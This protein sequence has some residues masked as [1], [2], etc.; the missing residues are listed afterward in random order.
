MKIRSITLGVSLSP[1]DFT[2]NQ[3]ITGISIKISKAKLILDTIKSAL[4]SE[5]YE[6]QTVRIS[7]NPMEEWI[8]DSSTESMGNIDTYNRES[9]KDTHIQEIMCRIHLLINEIVSHSISF[10][11][12]GGCSTPNLM[13]LIPNFLFL[14][15]RLYCSIQFHKNN[16]DF[17]SPNT[18]LL[19]I[20]AEVL[21][22]VH[23]VLDVSGCFRFCCSFNCQGDNPYFPVSY[24]NCNNGDYS[25]SIAMECGDLLFLSFFGAKSLSEGSLNLKIVLEQ[26]LKPVNLIVQNICENQ[27]GI[28]YAGI[29]ASINPGMTLPDSIGAGIENLFNIETIDNSINKDNH[30]KFGDFGT[31]AVVSAI[32]SA[33]KSLVSNTNSMSNN[34]VGTTDIK[35]TGY[36]GL[37]LPIM[38]DIILA[39][40]AAEKNSQLKIRDLLIFSS[41]CGVGIDT[42]PIPAS[43]T[44][45]NIA[46]LLMET[47][48]LAYRL[49]KP[50]SCR[51]L[52]MKDQ[53]AG[54]MT[55]L[56]HPYMCNTRIF[57]V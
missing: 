31:L 17:I 10:C 5:G 7:L 36:C 4:E 50:L 34:N 54:E 41:V 19:H 37:M 55:N 52:L 30:L 13:K 9:F 57:S 26:A 11:S 29:D 16:L 43:T 48:T 47:G 53:E 28:Q 27:L 20:A 12:L 22:E 6:V 40:R 51:L 14:S 33:I 56:E 3:G 35:L 18:S 15:D 45:R 2:D 38:E 49:D 23:R 44:V 21:H 1:N 46:G 25:V 24:H 32:T 42:V 39:E 8:L